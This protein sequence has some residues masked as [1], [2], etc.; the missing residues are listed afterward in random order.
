MILVKKKNGKPRVC[1]DFTDLSKAS[2]QDYFFLPKINMLVEA[3][4]NHKMMSFLYA[5]SSYKQIKM[6]PANEEKIS[7]IT[8]RDKYCYKIMLFRLKNVKATFQ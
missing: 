2:S 3:T 1:L 8:E 5:F 4:T 6:N 7:F